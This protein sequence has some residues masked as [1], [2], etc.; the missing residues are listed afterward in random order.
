MRWLRA[1]PACSRLA[2]LRNAFLSVALAAAQDGHR[3]VIHQ[4]QQIL[5]QLCGLRRPPHPLKT[6]W[7][8]KERSPA[9]LAVQAPSAASAQMQGRQLPKGG[10]GAT[11]G[12]AGKVRRD[13]FRD[14]REHYVERI[15]G[16]RWAPMG[17]TAGEVREDRLKDR[18]SVLKLRAR[19]RSASL[20]F[21]KPSKPCHAT[22]GD[23]K[24]S[25]LQC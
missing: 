2:L 20:A 10:V 18:S 4:L 19:L 17:R 24:A 15:Q 5:L 11:R 8:T 3:L 16:R 1:L 6:P 7:D 13:K 12:T 23:Y 14:R 25:K 21:W 9:D 22:P